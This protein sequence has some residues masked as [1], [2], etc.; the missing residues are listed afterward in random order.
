MYVSLSF[1]NQSDDGMHIHMYKF[2]KSSPT[3]LETEPVIC[4]TCNRA[5]TGFLFGQAVDARKVDQKE[6]SS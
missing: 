5:V 4:R 3:H 1:A 6:S 2:C